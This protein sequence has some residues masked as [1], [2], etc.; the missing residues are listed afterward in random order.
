[1]SSHVDKGHPTECVC[2]SYI[3]CTHSQCAFRG[4]SV[5]C[6]CALLTSHPQ[7]WHWPQWSVHCSAHHSGKDGGGGASGRVPDCQEPQNTA[8]SHGPDPGMCWAECT[9]QKCTHSSLFS[10]H[11]LLPHLSFHLL[12]LL[13]PLLSFS[14][15][16]SSTS[17]ATMLRWTTWSPLTSSTSSGPALALT[18]VPAELPPTLVSCAAPDAPAPLPAATLSALPPSGPHATWS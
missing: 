4:G 17:S 1:M 18:P 8:A 10:F 13:S 7:Q 11:P 12:L 6:D 15:F 3:H 14:P 2:P 16:R 9:G 5:G